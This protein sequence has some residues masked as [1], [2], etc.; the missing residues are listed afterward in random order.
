[1]VNDVFMNEYHEEM[2]ILS[3]YLFLL[4]IQGGGKKGMAVWMKSCSGFMVI[5]AK[6]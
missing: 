5:E 6:S 2:T 4:N 1:M 3:K